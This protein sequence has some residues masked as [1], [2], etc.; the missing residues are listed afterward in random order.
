MSCFFAL[1]VLTVPRATLLVLWAI[2]YFE[3]RIFET[4]IWPFL[5]FLFMPITTCV[6]AFAIF[7]NGG[8]EGIWIAFLI[9]GV[10]LDMSSDG[11]VSSSSSS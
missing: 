3:G 2:D 7:W 1:L 5:G 4:F 10:V 6:Y 8:V 9:L 11:S